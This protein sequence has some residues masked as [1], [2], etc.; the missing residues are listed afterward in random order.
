M[1]SGLRIKAK[2]NLN[3]SIEVDFSLRGE[4]QSKIKHSPSNI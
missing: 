3:L 4:A 2:G 1:K